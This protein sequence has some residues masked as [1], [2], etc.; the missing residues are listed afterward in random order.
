[1]LFLASPDLV[2]HLRSL[3]FLNA[4]SL[5]IDGCELVD[6]GCLQ[7]TTLPYGDIS[8]PWAR[9]AIDLPN[10]GPGP[11]WTRCFPWILLIQFGRSQICVCYLWSFIWYRYL[12]IHIYVFMYIYV[13]LCYLCMI[14]V[15]ENWSTLRFAKWT[16]RGLCERPNILW[17]GALKWLRWSLRWWNFETDCEITWNVG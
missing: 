1:M 14:C 4:L 8:K 5:P 16:G 7:V 10:M 13:I 6:V 15:H 2:Q 11:C 17:M 3:C 12:N 9:R